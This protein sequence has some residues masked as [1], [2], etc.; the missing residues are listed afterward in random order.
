MILP[1]AIGHDMLGHAAPLLLQDTSHRH[2][3]VQS[4]DGQ[5]PGPEQPMSH[6][7]VPHWMSPHAAAPE[8]SMSQLLARAHWMSPQLAAL[9][10]MVQSKPGGH[11][12]SPQ[13]WVASQSIRQVFSSRSHDVHGSGHWRWLDASTQ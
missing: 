4:I 1:R 9:H 12:R 6:G 10:R 11:V 8:H 5:A 2:D 13:M 3:T 7:A